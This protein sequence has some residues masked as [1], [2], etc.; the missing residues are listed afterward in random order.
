MDCFRS[1]SGMRVSLSGAQTERKDSTSVGVAYNIS[2]ASDG[3]F[4]IPALWGAL[5]A[6]QDK[7]L[8]RTTTGLKSGCSFV[9]EK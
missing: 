3:L 8:P 9:F 2:Q 5:A 6:W 1:L 7:T 4:R